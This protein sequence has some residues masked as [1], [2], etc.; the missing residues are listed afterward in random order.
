MIES[1]ELQKMLELPPPPEGIVLPE[2]TGLPWAPRLESA[3]WD[4]STGTPWCWLHV[5]RLCTGAPDVRVRATLVGYFLAPEEILTELEK[6]GPAENWSLVGCWFLGVMLNALR[7]HLN[8][9]EGRAEAET[10]RAYTFRHEDVPIG[11]IEVTGHEAD[12]PVIPTQ[13]LQDA[14][15]SHAVRVTGS[16]ETL[17]ETYMRLNQRLLPSFKDQTFEVRVQV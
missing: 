2:R 1:A 7:A 17:V 11:M 12:L 9:F 14:Y 10:K 3:F 15:V 6:D 8:R 5:L 16:L 4:P 13:T